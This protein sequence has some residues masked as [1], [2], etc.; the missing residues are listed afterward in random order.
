MP[1]KDSQH[2]Q[3]AYKALPILFHN[4]SSDFLTY[5]A[6]DG[7]EFLKFYWNYVATETDDDGKSPADG[8]AYEVREIAGG[9]KLVLITLP[10][11]RKPPE[12]YFLAML[13][14]PVKRSVL[15]WRNYARVVG[16]EYHLDGTHLCD[17]TPRALRVDQGIGPRPVLEDFYK[18]ARKLM[19]FKDSAGE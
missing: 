17:L 2:Y 13:T 6:R 14:P 19:K 7:V 11:P 3:F 1:K 16:L 8:M 4:Q 12:A 18:A 15:P 10:K 9:Q 5:L